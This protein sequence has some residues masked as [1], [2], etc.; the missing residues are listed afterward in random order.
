MP[1]KTRTR[2]DPLEHEVELGLDPGEFISDRACFSFVSH[3][4]EVAAKIGTLTKT[5][6]TRA[7]ALHEAFLAGCYEKAKE[8]D[9]SSGSFGQFVDELI[10][11]WIQ[12]RQAASAS[13]RG[14]VSSDPIRPRLRTSR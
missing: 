10:C 13:S 11:G 9:D 12:A 14:R 1:R 5:A 6:P 8:L 3:L 7:I 2:A 4:Y